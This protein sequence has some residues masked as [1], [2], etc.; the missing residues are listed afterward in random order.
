VPSLDRV[1]VATTEWR[2]LFEI[3]PDALTQEA[4]GVVVEGVLPAALP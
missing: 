3:T 1:A 4:L 2:R